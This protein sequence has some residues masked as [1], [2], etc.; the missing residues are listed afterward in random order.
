[1]PSILATYVLL[2]PSF[3]KCES[4]FIILSDSVVKYNTYRYQ[5]AFHIVVG[6]CQGK[7]E[8]K[9]VVVSFQLCVR[10][11]QCWILVIFLSLKKGRNQV[12]LGAKQGLGRYWQVR[13]KIVVIEYC[14]Y[15]YYYLSQMR[16]GAKWKL[17]LSFLHLGIECLLVWHTCTSRFQIS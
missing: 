1:M 2:I 16:S 12:L 6:W 15:V 14:L 8:Y 3:C 13:K 4:N 9:S 11:S 17:T 7:Y 10:L 5:Q